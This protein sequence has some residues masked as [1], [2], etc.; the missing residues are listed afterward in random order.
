MYN[1]PRF[2]LSVARAFWKSQFPEATKQ[3]VARLVVAEKKEFYGDTQ[4]AEKCLCEAL[5]MLE[6]TND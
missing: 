5:A 3:T 2:N 4:A 1:K 6:E